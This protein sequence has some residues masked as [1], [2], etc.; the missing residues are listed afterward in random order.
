[1]QMN[2]V[3]KHSWNHADSEYVIICDGIQK[4]HKALY[5][6]RDNRHVGGLVALE[7]I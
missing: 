7:A 3:P 1:M 4:K 5:I 2:Y 6:S